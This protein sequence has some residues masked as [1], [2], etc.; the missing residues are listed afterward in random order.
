MTGI[1][2]FSDPL[3]NEHE[4]ATKYFGLEPEVQAEARDAYDRAVDE[5]LARDRKAFF[6]ETHP[7]EQAIYPGDPEYIRLTREIPAE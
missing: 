4:R 3:D 6:E 1:E 5:S 7:A 2:G